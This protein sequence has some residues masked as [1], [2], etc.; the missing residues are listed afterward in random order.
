MPIKTL[1]D[2]FIDGVKDIFYAEKKILQA[3]KKMG[4]GAKSPDLKA[5]FD[6][7]L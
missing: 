3:L 4:R 5:A 1:E 7:H 6:K 2:L